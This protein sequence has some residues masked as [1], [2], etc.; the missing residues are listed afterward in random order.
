MSNADL[1]CLTM[2]EAI[3]LRRETSEVLQRLLAS[4]EQSDRRLAEAGKRDPMKFVTGQTSLE[5]AISIAREMITRLDDLIK[6]WDSD[7]AIDEPGSSPQRMTHR[8]AAR[9]GYKS[10][11]RTAVLTAAP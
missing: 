9:N 10:V 3:K 8:A 5:N 7:L 4:R 11:A 6:D 2:D 1:S